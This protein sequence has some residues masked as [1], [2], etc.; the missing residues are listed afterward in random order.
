MNG[1]RKCWGE[2]VTGTMVHQGFRAVET[3]P[4]IYRHAEWDVTVSCHGDDFLAEGC[5]DG[6]DRLDAVMTKGFE[7]KILPRIGARESGGMVTSA[8]PHQVGL[9]TGFL[10]RPIQVCSAV[11]C[12]L[13]SHRN[14][15]CRLTSNRT[16][17]CPTLGQ[18]SFA[19]TPCTCHWTARRFS[20]Q[21]LESQQEWPSQQ[22]Q[23][24][25]INCG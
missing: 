18:K 7:V 13:R 17:H 5:T 1:T 11:I 23:Q 6:L 20:L 3:L 10:G 2:K 19:G 25:S 21:W 16:R 9:R 22:C 8:S 24:C 4:G 14:E 12:G 15:R